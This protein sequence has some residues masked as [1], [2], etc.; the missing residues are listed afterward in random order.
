VF[1][2]WKIGG[3]NLSNSKQTRS[4]QGESAFSDALD[5]QQRPPSHGEIM[6]N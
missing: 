4:F 3:D 1:P 5:P 6:T 2:S